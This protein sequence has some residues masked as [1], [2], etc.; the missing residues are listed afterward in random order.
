[1][2]LFNP[3]ATQMVAIQRRNDAMEKDRKERLLRAIPGPES[4]Q[5][6]WKLRTLWDSLLGQVAGGRQWQS[7][8]QIVE[9]KTK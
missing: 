7:T 8:H 1:M 5:L 4:P 9:V 2:M 6:S 3:Y